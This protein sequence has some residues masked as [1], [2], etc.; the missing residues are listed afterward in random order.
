M[1]I[2]DLD[3]EFEDEEEDKSDA[4]AVDVDLS[5]S[6]SP[7]TSSVP[8]NKK[9][10][11]NNSSLPSNNT[12]KP[13]VRTSAAKVA[14]K[15]AAKPTAQPTQTPKARAAGNVT[16]IAEQR[17]AKSA[18]AQKPQVRQTSQQVQSPVQAPVA[19]DDIQYELDL[20]RSEIAQLKE[21]LEVVKN[22]SDIKVAVAEAKTEFMI[23]YITNAK[24]LDHQ[25]NQIMQRIHKKVPALKNEVLT[26]KKYLNEFLQK[27]SKKK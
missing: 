22:Q 3:L 6:A 27:S 25:V 1:A 21:Q 15:P 12:S 17:A 9:V 7:E 24:L 2:E 8:S 26:V 5:F 16:N 19:S 13:K 14:V 23:E 10:V 4:L 20:L 11:G 18:V